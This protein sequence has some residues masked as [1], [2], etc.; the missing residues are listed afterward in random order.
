MKATKEQA[1]EFVRFGENVYTSLKSLKST[2]FVYLF[3]LF[4]CSFYHFISGKGLVPYILLCIVT[5]GR[6]LLYFIIK[7]PLV[8]KT[9][10]LR[11][12]VDII[13][14]M[15]LTLFLVFGMLT[16]A[17]CADV[18]ASLWQISELL[19]V[20]IFSPVA[21]LFFLLHRVKAGIFSKTAPASKPKGGGFFVGFGLLGMTIARFLEGYLTQK[22]AM[23]L[24]FFCVE[25]LLFLFSF[26]IQSYLRLYYVKKFG[27]TCD[28]EGNTT[29]TELCHVKTGKPIIRILKLIGIILLLA[30][31]A[32]IVWAAATQSA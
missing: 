31:S 1:V 9:Y 26:S 20:A 29:S 24:L 3:L 14:H 30:F 22:M 16:I 11:Y 28:A 25:I 2:M 10:A 32:I 7:S 18:G 27:I 13:W 6:I 5:T 21:M 23:N 15:L 4:I 12:Y 17:E 19:F 8:K